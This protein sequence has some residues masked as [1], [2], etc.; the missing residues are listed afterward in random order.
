MRISAGRSDQYLAFHT[1]SNVW[2]WLTAVSFVIL[3]LTGLNI[4]FGKILLLP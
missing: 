2:H 3:G 4:S 1:V